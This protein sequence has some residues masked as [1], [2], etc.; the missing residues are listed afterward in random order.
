MA[1]DLMVQYKQP[2]HLVLVKPKMPEEVIKL[3]TKCKI[4]IEVA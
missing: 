3:L 1:Q 2:E 4:L